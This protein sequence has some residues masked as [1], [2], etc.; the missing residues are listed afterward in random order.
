MTTKRWGRRWSACLV[1]AV[2]AAASTGCT[3]RY[4][5]HDFQDDWYDDKVER[6]WA[7]DELGLV[8]PNLPMGPS[9]LALS[10]ETSAHDFDIRAVPPTFDWDDVQLRSTSLG[11]R[12]F[13][14]DGGAFRPYGGG[15]YAR[16]TLQGRWTGPNFE[17]TPGVQ[18]TGDCTDQ[19]TEIL[20]RGYNPFVM[21]GVEIGGTASVIVV[22]WRRTL[23]RGDGFY[24]LSGDRFSAGFRWRTYSGR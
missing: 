16:T 19:F 20:F 3:V 4:A 15:G 22:E 10:L 18:C 21:A 6:G 1:M 7:P 17:P 14:V 11:A 2:V 23:D 9:G 12:L 5:T 13:P 24:R 8:T